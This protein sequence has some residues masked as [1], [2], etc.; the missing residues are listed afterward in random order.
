MRSAMGD[1]VH[2]TLDR[3][4]SHLEAA[5]G[6]APPTS[7][8][9]PRGRRR[10]RRGC[11]DLGKRTAVPPAVIWRRTLDDARVLSGPSARLW[12]RALPAPAPIG[13]VPFGGPSPSRT[14]ARPGTASSVEIPDTGFRIAGYIDRLDISGDGS[15]RSGAR[16]QD[17]P[18]AQGQHLLNGGKELQRCLYAFA[19]KALLGEDVTISASLLYPARQIDLR[20]EDPEAPVESRRLSARRAR[21][22]FGRRR[23]DRARHRRDL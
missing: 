12:R 11:R 15:A 18:A 9:S 14:A 20:L 5:G 1:L 2:M 17:G 16:L 4:A 3:R 7:A 23:S 13:E 8:R 19:V 21:P 6:L 10:R 22:V